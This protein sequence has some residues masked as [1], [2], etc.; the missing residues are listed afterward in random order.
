MT[1]QNDIESHPQ[2]ATEDTPLIDH[3]N[4]ELLVHPIHGGSRTRRYL[5]FLVKAGLAVCALGIVA[6]FVKGWIDG[7]SDANVCTPKVSIL[8]TYRNC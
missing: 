7:G 1:I 3:E 5:L 6:L 2:E 4:S 8:T